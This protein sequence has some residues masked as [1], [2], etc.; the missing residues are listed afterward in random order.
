MKLS[1]LCRKCGLK[2]SHFN[3]LKKHLSIKKQCEKKIESY[4][5]SD[6]Q[7]LILSLLPYYENINLLNNYELE[8]LKQSS[9]IQKNKNNLL[10]NLD[11]IDK[12]KLKKCI[13]CDKEFNKI[14]DLR[15]HILKICFFNELNKNNTLD[16][17]TK[18]LNANIIGN[19]N[20]LNNCILNNVNNVTNIYF[21][22][23]NPLPF[24]SD[25]DISNIDNLTKTDFLFSKFMYT[26][27][28]EEILKNDINLNVIIDIE[29]NSGIVYKNNI[30]QYIKMKLKDIIDKSMEKLNKHLSDIITTKIDKYEEEFI[31]KSK[32]NIENKL[33]IYKNNENIQR[34]VID[35][36]S[37]IYE[38][39]K[40]DAVNISNLV[41]N[42]N[43]IIEKNSIKYGF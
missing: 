5:F 34:I 1:Y 36:V 22:I 7:I 27:L 39:K 19:N 15:I 25:W 23:K 3:D 9:I 11:Y 13:Y 37:K 14:S 32:N 4:N 10:K 41:K 12:N 18:D 28:L 30:E 26:S 33:L 43:D 31:D 16:E 17:K 24:D 29:N 6:D 35:L 42:N 38:N 20:I 21:E 8:Y 40:D 2:T